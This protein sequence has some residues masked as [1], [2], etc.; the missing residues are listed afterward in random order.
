MASR[1]KL[2]KFIPEKD[3]DYFVCGS[4][5]LAQ[6]TEKFIKNAVFANEAG[7]N[8]DLFKLNKALL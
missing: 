5:L 6:N 7:G 4:Y 2:Y 8:Y 3:K 1:I